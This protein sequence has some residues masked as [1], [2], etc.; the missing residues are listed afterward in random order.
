MARK[1]NLE[2]RHKIWQLYC[3]DNDQAEIARIL[4]IDRQLVHYHMQKLKGEL[5]YRLNI[6][7]IEEFAEY[8]LRL[9]DSLEQEIAEV[10][11]KIEH[12]ESQEAYKLALSYR[13]YRKELK[14]DLYRIMGDGEAVLS[15]KRKMAEKEQ[16]VV[17]DND[18]RLH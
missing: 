1:E 5:N 13:E 4:K 7:S 9:M 17:P 6:K 10:S 15:L 3:K 18:N 11:R 12:F 16:M 8:R 14:T 2:L